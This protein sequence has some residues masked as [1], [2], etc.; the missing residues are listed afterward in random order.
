[1]ARMRSAVNL[2]A[3]AAGYALATLLSPQSVVAL[4]LV[5]GAACLVLGVH[6]LAG[7]GWALLAAGGAA[8]LLAAVLAKGMTRG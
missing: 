5:T 4:L 3:A 1:M 7:G 2:A 8:F 6:A